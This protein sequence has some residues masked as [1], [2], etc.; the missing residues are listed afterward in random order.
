[1]TPLPTNGIVLQFTS[2]NNAYLLDILIY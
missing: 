1:M 2:L